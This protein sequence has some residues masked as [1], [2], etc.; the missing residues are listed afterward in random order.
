MNEWYE[1]GCIMT[2]MVM[3]HSV[4]MCVWYIGRD[5]FISDPFGLVSR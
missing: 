4:Y 5:R 3:M 2:V 1:K